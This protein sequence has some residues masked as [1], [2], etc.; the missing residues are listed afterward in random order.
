MKRVV[1]YAT[2]FEPIT[3][4]NL[5]DWAWQYLHRY[6]SVNIEVSHEPQCTPFNGIHDFTVSCIHIKAEKLIRG[7]YETL[8][9]FTHDEVSALKLKAA[10]LPGQRSAIDDMKANAFAHGFMS[11]MQKLGR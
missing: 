3:V 9:L 4:I 6:G 10:F 2:D 8:M 7:N 5:Q 11:A 1:L